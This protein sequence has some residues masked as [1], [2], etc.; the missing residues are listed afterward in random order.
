[1]H[2]ACGCLVQYTRKGREG[3]GRERAAYLGPVCFGYSGTR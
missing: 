1:M 3:K 2:I